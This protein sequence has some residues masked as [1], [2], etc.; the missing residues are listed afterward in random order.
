[1]KEITTEKR[2]KIQ[3]NKTKERIDKREMN[4]RRARARGND[5]KGA[6]YV[7]AWVASDF[8]TL[9]RTRL[10]IFSRK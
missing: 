6:S 7:A 8:N 10:S 9:D 1:M 5:A 4:N 3:K 2:K